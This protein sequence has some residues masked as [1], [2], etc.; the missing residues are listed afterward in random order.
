MATHADDIATL[1]AEERST[2]ARSTARL[3]GVDHAEDLVHDAFV[4]YLTHAPE[5]DRPGAWLQRVTRNRALNELR[6][7]RVVSLDEDVAAEGRLGERAERDAVRGVLAQAL[8]S[9]PE[10][11]R[12]ALEL[13]FVCEQDYT[14]V[15]GALGVS[16]QQAH[17]VLH[18]ATRRLGREL[19]RRL[20]EP[21]RAAA[22][23]PALEQM[24]GLSSEV[25][26]H[27]PVACGDCR[28]VMDEL[29]ALR[30]MPAL[31]P[32]V[33]LLQRIVAWV[34]ARAPVAAEPAGQL[35]T[36]ALVFGLA[37][38]PFGGTAIPPVDATRSRAPMADARPLERTNDATA[39]TTG[40]QARSVSSVPDAA[41]P[42]T[43]TKTD[44]VDV[45]GAKVRQGEHETQGEVGQGSPAWTGVVVCD[46]PTAEC[47]P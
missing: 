22:C 12:R 29:H 41:P 46:D 42:P 16:V 15:A 23:V 35:A 47:A 43:Q 34:G 36:L 33:G 11:Y 7:A 45:G 5:A 38:A 13:R 6:R 3:V 25:T 14:E 20:A 1:Y 31:V 32:A 39:R 2:L 19:V 8:A 44:A 30:A 40:T 18:R 27:G 37:V 4:T 9:L 24:L 26:E 28:P 21:H 10:R 17:V